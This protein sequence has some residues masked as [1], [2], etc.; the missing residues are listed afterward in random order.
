MRRRGVG[1]R[2]YLAAG[3]W[4]LLPAMGV[5]Q[6]PLATAS[7]IDPV[8]G[9][10]PALWYTDEQVAQGKR[11]FAGLCAECHGKDAAGT[12]NWRRPDA[13]GNYP[14]PPLNGSAH[15]WH[16]SLE[17]LRETIRNGGA[18]LGGVMPGFADKLSAQ[19]IDAVIAW[20][21]SLWSDEVYRI[22]SRMECKSDR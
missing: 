11:L 5:G 20:F 9:D 22:W 10:C 13:N 2:Q 17:I 6:V 21:Q 7:D 18:P 12:P 15:T 14:P 3:A 16:H 4:L 8:S 1:A 19:E